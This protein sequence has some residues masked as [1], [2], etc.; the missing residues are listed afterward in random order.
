MIY[1]GIALL[2][3]A[4]FAIAVEPNGAS[5][6]KVSTSR[7]SSTAPSSD[8]AYAGNLT[9]LTITGSSITQSWQGYFGNVS[10]A[11]ELADAS[12]NVLYNWSLANPSGEVYAST[13]SSITWTNIQCF[14]FTATGTHDASGET[15]GATSLNGTNVSQLESA[16][17]IS[18]TDADGVDETFSNAN[19]HAAFFTANLQF[20]AGECPS[21]DVYD[22][23]GTGVDGNFEEVLMYEPTTT[24]VVYAALIESG[25]VNGFDNLD[26]DFEMLVLEDG[27][28]S[29][30]ATTNYY[31][32][33]ELE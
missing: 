33:V 12:G 11:I 18:P 2:L 17:G 13:N 29:D 1:I 26:H 25:A 6:T 8:A 28:G 20:S 23:T 14:N 22:S 15:A 30:T 7:A 31:F 24:S 3:V 10:G 19:N 27:H 32:F 16:F 5:I 4:G 21:T 9:E